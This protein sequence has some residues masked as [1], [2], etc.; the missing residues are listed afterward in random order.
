[1]VVTNIKSPATSQHICH[2]T[3]RPYK[4]HTISNRTLPTLPVG[5]LDLLAI[6][7]SNMMR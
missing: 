2:D 4:T 5:V 1:M 7:V 3:H 6:A